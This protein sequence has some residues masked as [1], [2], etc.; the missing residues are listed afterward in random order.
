MQDELWSM[1]RQKIKI[2]ALKLTDYCD[3]MYNV[4]S[5]TFSIEF[6]KFQVI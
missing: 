1:A 3:K 4:I 6:S 2:I 5:T